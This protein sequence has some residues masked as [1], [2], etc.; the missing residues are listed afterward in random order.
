L[1]LE[2][3]E[4]STIS[5]GETSLVKIFSHKKVYKEKDSVF[6]DGTQLV[7]IA[8]IRQLYGKINNKR[9]AIYPSEANLRTIQSTRTSQSIYVLDF[10]AAAFKDMRGYMRRAALSKRINYE[11]SLIFNL[12]PARGWFSPQRT[13]FD[14][15]NEV[16]KSFYNSYI[17]KNK[18]NESITDFSSFMRVFMK[19]STSAAKNYSIPMTFTGFLGHGICSPHS[20]GL[21]IDLFEFDNNNDV[22]KN[23]L[24]LR[25]EF[26]PFLKE[27]AKKF[28][29]VIDKNIPWRLI[30]DL[31]SI[32]MKKYMHDSGLTYKTVFN[33]YYYQSIDYDIDLLKQ[34]A[35]GFYNTLVETDPVVRTT[36]YCKRR[37]RTL[38]TLTERTTITQESLDKKHDINYWASKYLELRAAE[39]KSKLQQN[40]FDLAK[41]NILRMSRVVDN[42]RLM[43]YIDNLIQRN[44]GM[45]INIFK[46][47]GWQ[48]FVYTPAP[49]AK[50]TLPAVEYSLQTATQSPVETEPV[51]EAEIADEAGAAAAA[52]TGATTATQGS[53]GAS[54]PQGVAGTFNS[55]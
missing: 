39:T 3:P 33:D 46:Q 24:F 27:T 40:D 11:K 48:D 52:A 25:D 16:Y 38:Y 50:I 15:M 19:F 49:P 28:G 6:S 2:E 26:F 13:F 30:A 45:E 22:V 23:E 35:I 21:I 54:T 47:D 7:D 5:P 43:V 42:R 44:S 8:E 32:S 37:N 53:S 10:V 29:F 55:Y 1:A 9:R 51:I 41:K 14:T 36:K 17:R 31:S 34:Y 18:I 12:Q 20:S 4:K